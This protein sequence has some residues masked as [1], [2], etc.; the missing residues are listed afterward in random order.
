MYLLSDSYRVKGQLF[1]DQ[2]LQLYEVYIFIISIYFLPFF[3]SVYLAI[4]CFFEKSLQAIMCG[5][6]VLEIEWSKKKV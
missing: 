2:K 3:K 5:S 1:F 6:N 4:E